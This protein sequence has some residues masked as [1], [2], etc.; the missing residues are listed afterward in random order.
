VK[1]WSKREDLVVNPG[2]GGVLVREFS[3]CNWSK[4][5]GPG[6]N[7]GA[8]GEQGGSK[9]AVSGEQGQQGGSKGE[10]GRGFGVQCNGRG[11]ALCRWL[12]SLS[13]LSFFSE[14]YR[15]RED[16]SSRE[17]ATGWQGVWRT[18]QSNG[19]GRGCAAGSR[20]GPISG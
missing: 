7:I 20:A 5:G 8:R 10:A 15:V 17:P 14:A 12:Q 6:R 4:E 9:G 13:S 19:R 16:L 2:Q 11:R 1:L 18:V 3:A